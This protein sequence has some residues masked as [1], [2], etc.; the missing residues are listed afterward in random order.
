MPTVADIAN[1]LA[2]WAPPALAWE[3]DNIGLLVGSAAAEVHGIAVTLDVTL[4]VVDEAR[5]RN[6]DLIVTHH[7]LMFHPVRTVRTDSGE[8]AV[9]AELIRQGIS[10]LAVHTNADATEGGVNAALAGRLALTN[11]RPLQPAEGMWQRIEALV[12][13]PREQRAGIVRSLQASGVHA[14]R[15][16]GDS[17]RGVI[18]LE[19]PV[20]R[21]MDVCRELELRVG[22]ALSALSTMKLERSGA[23]FG[24]GAVGE[25]G[26][27]L[28][29]EDF[30]EH[31]RRALDAAVLRVSA[32][33]R[34]GA[35]RHVA[36]CGGAGASSLHA[37][38]S[39]GADAYVTA[40]LSYHV[41]REYGE[42]MLIVDAGHYETEQVFLGLCVDVLRRNRFLSSAEIGIFPVE[43][44]TN[45]VR[46][47][48][49]MQETP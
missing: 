8:G 21:S 45:A 33:E 49:Y 15:E 46:M 47:F 9:I 10:L 24:M 22:D 4:D 39:A 23:T 48:P 25:L 1:V 41:F 12:E 42:R 13:L 7:P 38:A 20:W 17:E 34:R 28:P 31:V 16:S 3:K 36:L 5:R 32:G 2:E 44:R 30:L 18:V 35:V 26:V 37:A 40:D 27:P 14:C 43:T 11:V 19:I 29:V 6:A